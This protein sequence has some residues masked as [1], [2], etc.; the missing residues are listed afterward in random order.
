MDRAP[1]TLNLLLLKHPFTTQEDLIN[2]ILSHY[3]RQGLQQVYKI[4]GSFE[5][6]GSPLTLIN[7]LGTGVYDFFHEPAKGITKSP[8]DFGL[9]LAK[10]TKSLISATVY[11]IFNTVTH[12]TETL[13]KGKEMRS[14]YSNTQKV[15]ENCHWM[16]NMKEKD[17]KENN[18]NMLVKVY[19]LV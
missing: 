6:L 1:L 17:N 10:G 2:R 15:W 16:Q 8:K 9:G 3:K 7:N 5:M 4:L 12:I 14:K 18:L 19:C 11:G 13:N